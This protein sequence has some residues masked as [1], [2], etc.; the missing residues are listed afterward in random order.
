MHIFFSISTFACIVLFGLAS[1]NRI[2]VILIAIWTLILSTVSLLNI[3]LLFP[4]SFAL[5]LVSTILL[6]ISYYRLSKNLNLGI[7]Y[8]LGIHIIRIPVEF[9]LFQLYKKKMLPIEMTFLGWNYDLF[10]G[11][12]AV[13]FLIYSR[14]NPKILTSTLFKLWNILGIC[15]LF[16]VV[17]IGILSSPL[18]LQSLAFDH[19]NIAVL[20]FPFVLLPT[21]VVPIVILSHFHL[22]G[23]RTAIENR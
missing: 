21:I 4:P 1:P 3:F 14:P 6:S 5:V 22:L 8:L 2:V 18:P 13:L 23:N 17:I 10:F 11:I 15:S 19:P 12:T 20:Q 9:I 7:Y 16:E